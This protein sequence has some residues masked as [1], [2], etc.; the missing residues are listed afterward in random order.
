[1]HS[2]S[3]QNAVSLQMEPF[4]SVMF[5]C[6]FPIFCVT[7]PLIVFR[8]FSPGL[9]CYFCYHSFLETFLFIVLCNA[10]S[11]YLHEFYLSGIVY[12]SR[13]LISGERTL[14]VWE[15]LSV[16]MGLLPKRKEKYILQYT[17]EIFRSMF[18]FVIPCSDAIF[19]EIVTSDG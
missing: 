10:Q 14:P 5:I 8:G 19:F 6:S 15:Q 13:R 7:L 1:M 9:Q 18:V 16:I 11:I 12:P 2:D 17:V 4:L 3:K